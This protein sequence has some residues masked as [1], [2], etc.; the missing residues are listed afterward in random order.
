MFYC[1]VPRLRQV[2]RDEFER[3]AAPYHQHRLLFSAAHLVRWMLPVLVQNIARRL[4]RVGQPTRR[5]QPPTGFPC[6][7]RVQESKLSGSAGY[8][9]PSTCRGPR[10]FVHDP[11]E[12]R[13]VRRIRTHSPYLAQNGTN[14]AS[15]T[16][17]SPVLVPLQDRNRSLSSCAAGRRTSNRA[18]IIMVMQLAET[19]P[20]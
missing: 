11:K 1:S 14:L 7:M 6:F 8:F 13:R 15:V 9:W 4:D 10:L 3:H 19:G 5:I 12:A 17:E 2:A 20:T 16:K 18:N